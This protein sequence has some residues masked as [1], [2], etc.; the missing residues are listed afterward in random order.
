MVRR[1]GVA[2]AD[3][4]RPGV[5]TAF[6]ERVADSAAKLAGDKDSAQLTELSKEEMPRQPNH[7]HAYICAENK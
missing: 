4:T 1:I 3:I 6:S 5:N 2:R 7:E